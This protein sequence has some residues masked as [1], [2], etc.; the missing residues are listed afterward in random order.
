MPAP[1]VLRTACA[2]ADHLIHVSVGPMDSLLLDD[3]LKVVAPYGDRV[4]FLT[5]PSGTSLGRLLQSEGSFSI[6]KLVA[7]AQPIT[8]LLMT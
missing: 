4:R 5:L 8:R 6:A 7:F 1:T 3:L 2:M